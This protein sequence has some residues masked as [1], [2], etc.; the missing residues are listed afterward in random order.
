MISHRVARILGLG[1]S[2]GLTFSLSGALAAADP[3]AGTGTTNG[4]QVGHTTN[5]LLAATGTTKKPHKKC[6]KPKNSLRQKLTKP[7]HGKTKS[8]HGKTRPKKGTTPNRL[9]TGSLQVS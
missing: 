6:V 9:P 1:L 8:V 3:T 7:L 4:S 2:W 5:L